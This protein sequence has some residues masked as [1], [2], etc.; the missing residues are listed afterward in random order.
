M[1]HLSLIKR[2][3]Y[4]SQ[5][6]GVENKWVFKA[7]SREILD[8][9]TFF[10]KL[11]MNNQASKV[12]EKPRDENLMTKLWHQLATNNLLVHR[13][14]KF[15]QLAKLVIVQVINSV[16]DERTFSTL[17]FMKSKLHNRL[18]GHL[19]I[20]ICMF[21]EKKFTEKTYPFQVVIMDLSDGDKVGIGMNA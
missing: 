19:D 14:S 9:Q 20:A 17:T 2:Q 16:E 11:T 5:K 3:Y 6:F 7:L 4:I 15:M 8:L 18:V 1:D 10:F 13:L 21:V 12:M